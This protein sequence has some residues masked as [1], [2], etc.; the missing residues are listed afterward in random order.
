L[1]GRAR[2]LLDEIQRRFADGQRTEEE[3]QYLER[4]LDRF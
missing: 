2:D 1:H 4:L 3:R